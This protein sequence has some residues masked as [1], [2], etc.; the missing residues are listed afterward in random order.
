MTAKTDARLSKA[1]ANMKPRARVLAALNAISEGDMEC[2]RDLGRAAPKKSYIE[3][4]ATESNAIEACFHISEVLDVVFYEAM[5][6]KY[7]AGYIAAQRTIDHIITGDKD[8][9][10]LEIMA[11]AEEGEFSNLAAS[12]ESAAQND[13][14]AVCAAAIEFAQEIGLDLKAAFCRSAAASD[15]EFARVAGMGQSDPERVK[16]FKAGFTSVWGQ[17]GNHVLTRSAA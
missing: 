16:E 11:E 2:F 17:Y 6:R 4:D 12:L 9:T 15:P 13:A 3:A 5:M 8:K 7:R 14:R 1:Y 10:P